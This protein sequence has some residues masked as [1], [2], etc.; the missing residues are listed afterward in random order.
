MV[1]TILACWVASGIVFGFAALKPVLV[2]E[3]VYHDHCTEEE[4]RE[5][6]DLCLQ[7]DLRYVHV[8][9]NEN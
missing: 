4:L 7:Q 9:L 3:G 8:P 5:G 1:F 2:S 6:V